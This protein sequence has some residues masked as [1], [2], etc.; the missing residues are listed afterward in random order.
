MEMKMTTV[1]R[2]SQHLSAIHLVLL[3]T[4]NDNQQRMNEV[5]QRSL[6]GQYFMI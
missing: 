3:N 5:A 4:T 1:R 2:L 6:N